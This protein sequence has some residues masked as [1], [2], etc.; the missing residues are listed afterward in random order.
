MGE[1]KSSVHFQKRPDYRANRNCGL[2]FEY[3][4]NLRG[5]SVN[6]NRIAKVSFLLRFLSFTFTLGLV[7]IKDV[8]H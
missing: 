7:Q 1:M 2:L 4:S 3:C 6:V 8:I 5:V